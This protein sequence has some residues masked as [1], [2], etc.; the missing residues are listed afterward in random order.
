MTAAL[1]PWL[2]EEFQANPYPHYAAMRAA[3]PVH[4]DEFRRSWMLLRYQDVDRALRDASRFSAEQGGTP[5]SM[6]VSDPPQH[7]RLRGLVSKAFTPSTVRRLRPRIEAIVD[8]LLDAAAQR[9]TID[10]IA[11]YAYPL[12]IT[13]IAELLGVDA[14][15]RFFFRAESQKIALAIGPSADPYASA[16]AGEGRGKLLAYFDDLIARRRIAPRDDLVSAMIQAEERG[17]L[18]SHSELL[19]MLLLLLVGGHETTVN[20]IGN[21]LLALLRNPEQ[22]ELLR[23]EAGFERQAVDELLR[24]D[25]PVQ[26]TG[27]VATED[28]EMGGKQIR[29]GERVRMVLASGNRDPEAFEIPDRLDLTRDPDLPH[30]SFGMGVHY[31]LGAELARVEGEIALPAVVRRFP[32][33]RLATETLRWRPASVMRGLEALPLD[34]GGA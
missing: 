14:E 5:N 13:V 21:G 29:A 12:P 23:T 20:L 10:A 31:C 19:A 18:L 6:L 1:S 33:M 27:R 7:T 22:L 9:E 4:F 17:D 11:E 3:A 34:L 25:S 2:T 15:D 16:R 32:R 26:Y 8:D 24:Y 28:I 30:L